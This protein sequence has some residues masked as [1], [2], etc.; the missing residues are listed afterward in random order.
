MKKYKKDHWNWMW[1][2]SS[3]VRLIW[4]I[5]SSNGAEVYFVGGCVRD[6]IQG[7]EI[8]DIDIATNALPSKVLELVQ[9]AGLKVSKLGIKY[10]SVKVI[11]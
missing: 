8:K 11:V 7:R 4:K 2:K 9:A 10:G 5:L 3:S 1:L 6:T